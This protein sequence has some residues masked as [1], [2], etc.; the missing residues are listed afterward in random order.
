MSFSD[1]HGA[2]MA[3]NR[4]EIQLRPATSPHFRDRMGA[5]SGCVRTPGIQPGRDSI[6]HFAP[7][8][9]SAGLLS[10]APPGHKSCGFIHRVDENLVLTHTLRAAPFQGRS[11]N[12]CR[13]HHYLAMAPCAL[14]SMATSGM[15]RALV[16]VRGGGIVP[17]RRKPATRSMATGAV[18]G[19]KTVAASK[20]W[21]SHSCPV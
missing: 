14:T 17:L 5:E 3:I 10:N 6:F 15:D 20:P 21:R 16:K 7:G 2:G 19:L 18:G 1:S 9:G 12:R 11:G 4:A 8:A 13:Q